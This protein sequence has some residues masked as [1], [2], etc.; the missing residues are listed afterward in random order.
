MK[1]LLVL[2]T[3]TGGV[4]R[5]VDGLAAGLLARGDE[6]VVTG[7]PAT[8][9]E[10][11][12]AGFTRV[13]L[14]VRDRPDPRDDPRSV[15]RI[16]RLSHGADVVHAHGIRAGALAALALARTPT[17]LVVTLHNA[18]P[19]GVVK[20]AVHALLERLVAGRADVVLGVSPDLVAGIR[21]VGMQGSELAV[22]PAPPPPAHLRDRAAVMASLDLPARL[23]MVVSVGRLAAQKNFDLLLD[24]STA[25]PTGAV[26]VIV[27][28]VPL[29]E[30]L[31]RRAAARF[32]RVRLVGRR[33]DVPEILA[34]AD[35]VVS[36]A[37]WEGQPLWLQEALQVGAAIVATDVGGTAA[38]LGGAG[39]LVPARDAEALAAGIRTVLEDPEERSRLRRLARQRATRLPTQ[40]DAVDAATSIYRDATRRRGR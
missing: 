37:D 3:S 30:H 10:L 9:T 26:V 7:P 36:S 21:G 29:G 16:R 28:D 6:V 40:T 38:I 5:H 13:P 17:P 23:R 18:P 20:A 4:V 24:A 14:A 25:L 1:V 8:L 35:V 39:L 22:V 33:D 34:A 19:R 2:G 11:R 32:P 15:L 12:A 27:G 31:V